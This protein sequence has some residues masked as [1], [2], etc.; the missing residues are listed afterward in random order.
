[1]KRNLVLCLF[2]LIKLNVFVISN[3]S[4]KKPTIVISILIRNKAHT[5]PYFLTLFE[6]LEYPKNRICLWIRSDN[7]V[8]NSI[9]ILN[10]WLNEQKF[11]YHSVNVVT[12]NESKSNE[13][14]ESI[15]DW[16]TNRFIHVINLREEALNFGRNI[17]ADYLFMVDADV[18]L[19]NPKTLELLISKNETLVAPMLKSDGMYSNYWAG[20]TSE[21]Y[22]ERTDT[23]I[24]ILNREK[25]GCHP[26]PMIHSAVLINL[27]EKNT[28]FLTYN[29][30]NLQHYNGPK[31]DIITFALAANASDVPLHICNDE[32]YGYVMIPL[33][34]QDTLE[35]DYQQL[36][37]LKLEVLGYQAG[38]P[39]S[40]SMKSF[41][42]YPKKDTMGM[43]YDQ[44]DAHECIIALM[45]WEL[46]PR[47]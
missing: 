39:L 10:V 19:T 32:I 36:I 15:A 33:E 7:N 26:V 37:N 6:Q 20:M 9:E 28:D 22:Y 47:Q 2:I 21:Y 41:V 3:E 18:F 31:D 14:E 38:L 11:N 42:K 24:P 8:D 43:D 45:N 17:W 46:M 25:I 16:T 5:L 34:S 13:N 29:S 30:D 1:M 23:Y 12:D 4:V 35:R 40:N 44:K 27:R